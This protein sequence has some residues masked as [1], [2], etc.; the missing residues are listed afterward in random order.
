MTVYAVDC[1][2]WLSDKAVEDSLPYLDDK[3]RS[4]IRRLRV[5]LKRAQCAAAGLLLTH[6]FGEKGVAPNL[7]Y[8]ENGKPY[9][10]NR[11]DTFFSITHS[12]KWVFLAVAD[13]EI[14][15]DA[16]I[17]RKVCP[18]LAAQYLARGIGLGQGEHR[19]PF[20]PPMDDE[21]SLS[22]IHRNRPHRPHPLG[23]SECSPHR[24]LRQNPRLLL[25]AVEHSPP[26]LVVCKKERFL[27]DRLCRCKRPAVTHHSRSLFGYFLNDMLVSIIAVGTARENRSRSS[28]PYRFIVIKCIFDIQSFITG[29]DQ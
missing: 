5:P 17:P 7:T 2:H 14:G 12:D 26:L 20:H 23:L 27:G 18:R 15:I 29:M 25:V 3:R 24:W 22:Q 13:C 11:P 6:L 1:T 10:A 16:Q 21:G 9:L 19:A 4:R 28:C 8:G